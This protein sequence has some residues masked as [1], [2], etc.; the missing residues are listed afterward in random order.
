[1]RMTARRFVLTCLGLVAVLLAL[2]LAGMRAGAGS[3]QSG[4]Y[5][6]FAGP[7]SGWLQVPDDSALTP[8]GAITVEAWVYLDGY[9]GFGG[10]QTDCPM[11]VGKNWHDSYALDLACGGDIMESYINGEPMSSEAHHIPLQTWTH[12]AMT[13][14]GVNRRHYVNGELDLDAPDAL[15]PIGDSSDDLRIGN[16][17]AWDFSPMA[18]I[19]DV[20]IWNVALSQ[21]SI[22][23]TMDNVSPTAAGLVADWTFVEGSLTDLTG[24][25]TGTLVGDVQM[26]GPTPV[27]T[28]VPGLPVPPNTP[29]DFDCSLDIDS[30]DAFQEMSELA[31]VPQFRPLVPCSVPTGEVPRDLSDANC[32]GTFDARDPLYILTVIARINP[33]ATCPSPTLD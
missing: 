20:R 23:A 10:N 2:L 25:R 12:L 26:A 15:G 4:Q 18:R 13:Y 16:D 17:A 5:L 19:D 1:V 21:A 8:G 11:I 30:Y 7:H 28:E 27:P 14:N 31:H 22:Q 29:G 6:Q 9:G 33:P 3:A 24:G 32:D